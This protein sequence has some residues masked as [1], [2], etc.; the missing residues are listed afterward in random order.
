MHGHAEQAWTRMLISL[1]MCC[2]ERGAPCGCKPGTALWA[3]HLPA[4]SA[5]P[6]G[7][8]A[9]T[10]AAPRHGR[11]GGCFFGRMLFWLVLHP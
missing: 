2:G 7:P 4:A 5:L 8:A 3:H 11:R 6:A 10:S 1:C 9:A